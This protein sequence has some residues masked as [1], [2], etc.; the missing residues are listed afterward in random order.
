M[1]R[2]VAML[3]GDIEIGTAIS[4]PSYLTDSDFN[5]KDCRFQQSNV[6]NTEI[7]EGR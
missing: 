3:A 6:T 7:I 4:K 1:S 2:A 5:D